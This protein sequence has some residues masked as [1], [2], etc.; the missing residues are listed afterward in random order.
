[1]QACNEP[2]PKHRPEV[3]CRNTAAGIWTRL[4]DN[5]I[6]TRGDNHVLFSILHEVPGHPAIPCRRWIRPLIWV[7]TT[8][9]THSCSCFGTGK[10]FRP[11]VASYATSSPHAQSRPPHPQTWRRTQVPPLNLG[12]QKVTANGDIKRKIS[13]FLKEH[14]ATRK[15]HRRACC[16]YDGK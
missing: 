5:G 3:S 6:S 4:L 12:P 7:A 14:D 13:N 2:S 10:I 11:I 15:P 16:A 9:P 8:D 1:M